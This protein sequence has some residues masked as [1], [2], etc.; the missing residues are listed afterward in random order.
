MLACVAVIVIQDGGDVFVLEMVGRTPTP[1]AGRLVPPHE[2]AVVLARGRPAHLAAMR[3]LLVSRFGHWGAHGL[4]DEEVCSET[5]RLIARG[6]MT[7]H[8]R[9]RA[10]FGE[11]PTPADE[12]QPRDLAAAE[13]EG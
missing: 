3:D 9:T 1:D 10:G 11:A 13:Q 12:G 6:L 5:A 8:R 4:A 7:L 2:A